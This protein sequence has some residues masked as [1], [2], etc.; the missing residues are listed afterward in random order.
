MFPL[1]ETIRF[2]NGV[3]NNTEYHFRRVRQSAN[4]C[5]NEPL[6]FNPEQVLY[7]AQKS[8]E[9]KK[10]LFKFRLLYDA[11]Q[12]Q[13]EFISYQLPKIKSLKLIIDN[14][15]EYSHK[16]SDRV[17]LNQLR[18]QRGDNDDILIIKNGEVT[19]TSFA[20]II[21]YDGQRWLTPKHPLLPGTQRAY[22][23][24]TG[25]IFEAI[26]TPG[27]VSKFQKIRIINA[28]IRLVDE[29]DVRIEE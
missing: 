2:E 28:M 8:F 17:K 3:F 16:Y 23:L 19:D 12:H 1:L 10:G 11:L 25:T 21:F 5:F 14:Q 26:I 27:D 22:L 9:E 13:W 20:N 29:V 18:K 4:D 6:Q 15:I 24:E 7:K